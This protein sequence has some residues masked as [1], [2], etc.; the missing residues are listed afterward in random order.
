VVVLIGQLIAANTSSE[1]GLTCN[2]DSRD[3]LADPGHHHSPLMVFGPFNTTGNKVD[4]SG[5]IILPLLHRLQGHVTMYVLF[6]PTVF[7][8]LIV[9]FDNSHALKI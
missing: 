8:G 4:L 1:Q 6:N 7:M 9:H 5:V 3:L 2:P